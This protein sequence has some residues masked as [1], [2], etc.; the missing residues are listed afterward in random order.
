MIR[1]NHRLFHCCCQRSSRK[2]DV[3]SPACI[4]LALPDVEAKEDAVTEVIH[5][6]AE[7]CGH[8]HSWDHLADVSFSLSVCCA[9]STV[10]GIS[11]GLWIHVLPCLLGGSMFY[12]SCV[13][14]GEVHAAACA[15]GSALC[16]SLV[17][18]CFVPCR[19]TGILQPCWQRGLCWSLEVGCCSE[20]RTTTVGCRLI[21][22]VYTYLMGTWGA[23]TS[24]CHLLCLPVETM[25]LHCF[26]WA[27]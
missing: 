21:T 22:V 24:D 4:C 25:L 6:G 2:G 27:Y 8:H 3:C 9:F 17:G 26:L 10:C 18:S 5:G 1:C 12:K 14:G 15:D 13:F 23:K 19:G 7:T 16:V 11:A 20:E